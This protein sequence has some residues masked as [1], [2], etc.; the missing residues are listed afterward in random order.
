M[1]PG[2]HWGR[3]IAAALLPLVM[4]LSAAAAAEPAAL[5]PEGASSSAGGEGL[6]APAVEAPAP[7]LG[8][9]RRQAPHRHWR[10]SAEYRL[11]GL[12][13]ALKLD[14]AQQ[15]KVRLAL[16]AEREAIRRLM[17]APAGRA[18]PR[19][20]AIHA[21]TARTA[22]RIRAVLSDEQRKLYSQPLP[23]D[24]EAGEGRPGVG[25]WMS[26]MRPKGEEAQRHGG[27][28]AEEVTDP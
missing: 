13:K 22:E 3:A 1:T 14:D 17:N 20:A 6:S 24:F 15:A 18:V 28:H 19:V 11:Q 5:S 9:P 26:A 4:A 7:A 10:L 23:H 16:Q 27:E 12:S 2:T 25:E 8:F 21:I